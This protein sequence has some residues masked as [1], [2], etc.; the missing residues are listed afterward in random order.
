[1]GRVRDTVFNLGAPGSKKSLIGKCFS[2]IPWGGPFKSPGTS[3]AGHIACENAISQ[4][5][6]LSR[7]H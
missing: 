3:F 5:N 2:A 7:Y 1:M 6:N 4:I